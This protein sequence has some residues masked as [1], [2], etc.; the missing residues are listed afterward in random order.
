M[1][2]ARWQ[3][4]PVLRSALQTLVAQ[5]PSTNMETAAVVNQ[6]R[7]A[8]RSDTADPPAALLTRKHSI[9]TKIASPCTERATMLVS[10]C[11]YCTVCVAIAVIVTQ[12][13]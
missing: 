5:L 8:V 6:A 1:P 10:S 12:H 11:Q 2:T 3:R 9:A 4:L 7:V 13:D